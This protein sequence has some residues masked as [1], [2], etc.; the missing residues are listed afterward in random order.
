[1]QHDVQ[2]SNMTSLSR[3]H[4]QNEGGRDT[5][6]VDTIRDRRSEDPTSRAMHRD[7]AESIT[8]GLTKTERLVILLYYVEELTMKETGRALDLSESRV[9]QMHSAIITRLRT[10]LALPRSLPVANL[11]GQDALHG[12]GQHLRA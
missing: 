4:A 5:I 7:L 12:L 11:P 10:S 3:I 2:T 9:S 8:R 1:M 6:E